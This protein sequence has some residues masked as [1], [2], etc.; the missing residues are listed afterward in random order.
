MNTQNGGRDTSITQLRYLLIR[1]LTSSEEK[2]N[3]VQTFIANV[4]A[5]QLIGIGT[6][7]NLRSYIAE[8]SERKRNG[9]HR[10]IETTIKTEPDRFINRNSGLTITCSEVDV[11]DT[12]KIARLKNASLIN[13]A[14][15]QGEIRR[16]F[17]EVSESETGEI[18]DDF[19]FPVRVEINV[20]PDPSSVTETAIARN[21][22][23]A[24]QSISQAGARGHL[25]DL[26]KAIESARPGQHIR[27]SETETDVIE[28][29][30]ILQYTR[31][32]MPKTVSGNDSAA[33]QL[34]A[35][36]NKAQCLADFSEWYQ[37][38]DTDASAARKYSFTVQMAPVALREYEAWLVHE[39]W[40]GH[41]IWEDTKKG[42]RV[43]RR[44]AT[45]K[46]V[47]VAPGLMFPLVGALS[48]FVTEEVPGEWRLI[49]PAI[50]RPAE[51]IQRTV[52]QFRAHDSDPMAMGRSASAYDAIRT[53]TET[54]IE[55]LSA[56][57]VA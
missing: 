15:T 37:T 7:A 50:F 19:I 28:T 9:V 21:S 25:N 47:W 34:R 31:L 14:Q 41:R 8:F 5:D 24:V 43:C 42:G 53:Y 52:N 4:P 48:A 39:A 1:N 27:R 20:D 12:K 44:D 29:H 56:A 16:F 17:K 45:G 18:P 30:Q 26:A 13:G 49:K 6:G 32:L 22:A 11:D 54:I 55:V 57:Q 36:K 40:N 46:I 23:T 33:E 51:L 2:A 35:Y 10:A 38:K 3:N